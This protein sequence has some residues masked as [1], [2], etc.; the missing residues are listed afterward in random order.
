[1]ALG[2]CWCLNSLLYNINTIKKDTEALIEASKQVDL[3][4]NTKK[5]NYMLMTLHQN[6]GR[7]HNIKISNSSFENT[8]KSK[9]LR[10]T[11]TNQNYIREEIKFILNSE[12]S[13]YLSVQNLL[14]SRLLRVNVQIEIYQSLFYSVSVSQLCII[15]SCLY[16]FYITTCFGHY[17]W[18][19]SGS[20][21]QAHTMNTTSK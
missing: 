8:V 9:Y 6:V 3:E 20:S 21:A 11:L 1:M 14:C 2:P 4:A 17:F 19:S 12:N 10:T 18:P 13:C 16:G 5:T 7:N 15:L